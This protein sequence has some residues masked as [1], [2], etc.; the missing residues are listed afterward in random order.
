M[1]LQNEQVIAGIEMEI[2]QLHWQLKQHETDYRSALSSLEMAKKLLE[3]ADVQYEEGMI[4]FVEYQ[5][6]KLAHDATQLKYYQS[7]YKY[8]TALT[9]FLKGIGR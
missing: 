3:I 1:L 9:N 6:A 7:L 8:N 5:D 4:T 2:R